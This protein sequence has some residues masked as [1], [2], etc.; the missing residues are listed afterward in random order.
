MV[1]RASCYHSRKLSSESLYEIGL[2]N[3]SSVYAS[4]E[5]VKEAG[6]GGGASIEDAGDIGTSMDQKK[7]LWI[8]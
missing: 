6:E 5:A 7:M 8:P 1:A 4:E 3:F 2:E